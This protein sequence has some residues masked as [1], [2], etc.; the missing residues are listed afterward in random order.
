V[1][2]W[3]NLLDE[4]GPGNHVVQLY[5]SDDRSLLGNVG[6]YLGVGLKRGE[7]VLAVAAAPHTYTLARELSDDPTPREN[8]GVGT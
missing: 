4:P 1:P 3:M 2:A 7:G 6:W 8:R 5:G